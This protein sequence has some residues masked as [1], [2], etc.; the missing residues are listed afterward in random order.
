MKDIF[1][2][3]NKRPIEETEIYEVKDGMRSDRITDRINKLWMEEKTK[4]SPSLLRVM[5]K[6]YGAQLLFWGLGFSLFETGL[7]LVSFIGTK[8]ILYL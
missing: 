5:Y 6:M 3:G 8:K 1:K 2:I 4:K 7:R